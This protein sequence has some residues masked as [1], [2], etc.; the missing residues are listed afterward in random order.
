MTMAHRGVS[1]AC[2]LLGAAGCASKQ[3]PAE[4]A[5]MTVLTAKKQIPAM[6][7]IRK[8]DDFFEWQE[9]P[10]AVV[11]RNVL[12][13]LYDKD[14]KDGFRV[15][16]AFTEGSVL[17][18][19]D[20]LSGDLDGA[21]RHPVGLR[22]VAVAI[23][24]DAH[25][26]ALP[27]DRVDVMW[28]YRTESGE[29]KR[30]TILQDRLVLAMDMWAVREE[31]GKVRGATVTLALNSAEAEQLATAAPNGEFF[32]ARRNV[33]DDKKPQLPVTEPERK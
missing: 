23:T 32:L 9:K 24:P 12:T 5:R 26:F 14:I 3:V 6:T 20:L 22:A 28:S 1:S 19:D 27:G 25:S 15:A 17:T 13:D 30:Q 18:R 29:V 16:R 11:P 8:A 7:F 21:S 33:S 4:P 2:L 31:S 10:V